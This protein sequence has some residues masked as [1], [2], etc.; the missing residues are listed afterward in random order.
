MDL[1]VVGSCR[2]ELSP[3]RKLIVSFIAEKQRG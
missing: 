1:V 2:M 3:F